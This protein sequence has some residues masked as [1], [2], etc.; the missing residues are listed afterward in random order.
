MATNRS[1]EMLLGARY[2]RSLRHL[3]QLLMDAEAAAK[4]YGKKSLFGKDKFEP[5]FNT[6]MSSLGKCVVSLGA[7]GHVADLDDAERGVDAL[8]EAML[9]CEEAYGNWPMAFQFWRDYYAQFKAKIERDSGR[10]T[11]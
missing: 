1:L 5:A 10:G 9:R 8:N 4:A 11:S 7:D 3:Q 2:P 6:F